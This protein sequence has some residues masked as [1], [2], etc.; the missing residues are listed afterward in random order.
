MNTVQIAK[1]Y[2]NKYKENNQNNKQVKQNSNK[3]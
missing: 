2:S 3:I 1:R